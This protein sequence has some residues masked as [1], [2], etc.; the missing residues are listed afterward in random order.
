MK[1]KNRGITNSFWK[2]IIAFFGLIVFLSSCTGWD[3]F[4]EY[5]KDGEIV[6][7]GRIKSL[8]ILSGE[9]RVRVY[10]EISPDKN[11]T[12]L[13]IFW[14]DFKD[15]L[16][17]LVTEDI[18][19]NGFD[20]II[21]VD[22]GLKTFVVYTYDEFGNRSIPMG[23]IGVSYGDQYRAKVH[24]REVSLV[25]KTDTS[26]YII[27][28]PFDTSTGAKYIEVEYEA[29]TQM[30]T[31]F[32]KVSDTTNLVGLTADTTTI[33]YH[34]I[35]IPEDNCIDMFRSDTLSYDIKLK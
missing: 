33:R 25:K 24:N 14:D 9:E 31:L 28:K 32:T 18:R 6:Y 20:E 7:P 35:Y 8:T 26:T 19:I 17:L 16:Q 34:M 12:E 10:G 22:E 5:S 15:S 3:D 27:W 30:T 21:P 1:K 2:G 23:E 29:G 11:V 4:R 13:R